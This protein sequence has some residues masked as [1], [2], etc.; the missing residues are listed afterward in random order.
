[1]R[2]EA[3]AIRYVRYF[4]SLYAF[5]VL[6]ASANWFHRFFGAVELDQLLFHLQLPR[7]ALLSADRSLVN[8]A[9]RNCLLAPIAYAL[10]AGGAFVLVNWRRGSGDWPSRFTARVFSMPGQFAVLM[11]I[12]GYALARDVQWFGSPV[13]SRDWIGELYQPPVL[14][15]GPVVRR[16][17]V[18]IYAESLEFGW[19]SAPN[20]ADGLIKEL[21]QLPAVR[22]PAFTQLADTGWTIAGIVSTQCGLPLKPVGLFKANDT[23]AQ[24]LPSARCLGDVLKAHGYRNV[25]LGGAAAEFAGKGAF[26]SGHGYDEVWGSV[27]WLKLNPQFQ[28]N[29]WGLHDD[30]LFAQAKA[31]YTALRQTG[32]PFNLTL[33]TVGMHPPGGELAPSCPVR[34]HDYRD[35]VRC[36]S[37]LV[38][39]FVHWVQQNDP[40]HTTDIVIMGDHLGMKGDLVP[41]IADHPQRYVFNAFLSDQPLQPNRGVVNHFDMYPT[42]LQMLGFRVEG[43][44]SGLGCGALGPATCSTLTSDAAIDAKLRMRSRFYESLWVESKG[45][46]P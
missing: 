31:R 16:N 30:E 41:N 12:C 15:A 43:G 13:D 14:D 3:N 1:M 35:S 36:T 22:F 4:L 42:M 24:F 44:R 17:L 45:A 19:E 26:F 27:E 46:S 37:L 18:L 9:V 2:L 38:S 10:L 40:L 20:A 32:E 34:F 6:L 7:S 28:M 25:F 8:S 11:L 21:S 5:A 33:L 23:I 39:S 29:G